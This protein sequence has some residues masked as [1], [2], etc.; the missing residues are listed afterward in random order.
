M[1]ALVFVYVCVCF[2]AASKSCSASFSPL[3][4]TLL[5]LLLP[6]HFQHASVRRGVLQTDSFLTLYWV[7]CT[8]VAFLSL[9]TQKTIFYQK[10]ES[11]KSNFR[12]LFTLI[13]WFQYSCSLINFLHSIY[14]IR[15]FKPS[16]HQIR[17]YYKS[18]VFVK[19]VLLTSH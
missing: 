5:L 14:S 17:F 16:R 8:C 18:F 1:C 19:K 7:C 2:L 12:I 15:C 10:K 6:L 13:E 4:I 11:R 9:Y 3:T